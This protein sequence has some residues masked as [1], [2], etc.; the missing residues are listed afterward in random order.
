M[1]V[2][3]GTAYWTVDTSTNKEYITFV[4]VTLLGKTG[5]VPKIARDVDVKTAQTLLSSEVFSPIVLEVTIP[6]AADYGDN[7]NDAANCQDC[8]FPID[9]SLPKTRLN[10]ATFTKP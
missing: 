5:H 1:A 8:V 4:G 10:V 6:S 2:T 3:L 9:P 7:P